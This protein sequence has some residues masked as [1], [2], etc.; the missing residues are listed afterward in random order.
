VALHG[1]GGVRPRGRE[2]QRSH[3]RRAR[4][5]SM[6][7]TASPTHDAPSARSLPRLFSNF[8]RCTSC[9]RTTTAHRSAS[10]VTLT[11]RSLRGPSNSQKNTPCQVESP[12]V[13][14]ITGIVSDGPIRPAL[15]CASPLPSWR[16]CNQT[17]GRGRA[18]WRASER[19]HFSAPGVWRTCDVQL[20]VWDFANPSGSAKSLSGFNQTT[21]RK[22]RP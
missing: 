13:P 1:R 16:S 18:N 10:T 7:T 8:T 20:E 17:L 4:S 6:T 2:P 22:P 21:R 5:T 19:Q 3:A 9:R 14:S 15:R 12:S 11:L